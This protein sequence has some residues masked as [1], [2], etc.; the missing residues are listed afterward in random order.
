MKTIFN[1]LLL[2]VFL[3]VS[4]DGSSNSKNNPKNDV[5][6]NT[7][8]IAVSTTKKYVPKNYT[9]IKTDT[10]LQNGFQ[11]KL[12]VFSNL[13]KNIPKIL[14]NAKTKTDTFYREFEADI[15]VNYNSKLLFKK[16]INKQFILDYYQEIYNPKLAT[17]IL[18]NAYVLQQPKTNNASSIILEYCKPNNTSCFSYE[19]EVYKDGSFKLSKY[20]KD[21]C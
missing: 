15:L 19:I 4:C 1:C 17:V 6:T 3:C 16:R 18:K 2:L 5:A 13:E 11:I 8:L 20:N 9:E 21:G 12:N 7:T 10:L 14:S